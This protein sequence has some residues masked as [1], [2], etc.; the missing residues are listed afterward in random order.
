MKSLVDICGGRLF[1]DALF[2]CKSEK[3]LG[4]HVI[5]YPFEIDTIR[6]WLPRP[7]ACEAIQYLGY[8]GSLQYHAHPRALHSSALSASKGA[9]K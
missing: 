5:P 2:E 6:N 4:C 3:A 8:A 1:V 7:R 9:N